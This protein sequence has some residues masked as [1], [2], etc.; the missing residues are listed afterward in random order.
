VIAAFWDDL[1]ETTSPAG[2]VY[3]WYDSVNH[4]WIVEWSYLRNAV[5]TTNRETFEAIFYDPAYYQ[6]QTGDGIIVFQYQVV[7]NV[8]T[9]DGYATVGIESP[10]NSDGVL[11]TYFL[12][13]APGAAT[14]ASGRVIKFVPKNLSTAAAGEPPAAGFGFS[15]GAANPVRPGAS[16]G[17]SLDRPARVTL[18]VFDIQ[19]R[20]VRRLA[21]GP[22]VAGVHAVAWDGR[23]RN[24]RLL[25]AGIYL[26][27]L[28][29]DGRKVTRKV[30]LGR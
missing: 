9:T 1:F 10:D 20:M 23:D 3:Q 16:I 25:P 19:G 21:D 26:Q 13:Y 15:A 27:R 11:Y 22:M 30:L 18:E 8:D 14:L 6:T 12:Q 29:A 28:E 17:F 2:H 24:G 7:T 5:G 4:L